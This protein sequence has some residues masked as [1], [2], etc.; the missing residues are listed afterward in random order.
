MI[1]VNRRHELPWH[2]GITVREVLQAMKYTY[3]DIVVR[4]D[5]RVVPDED[6]DTAAIPD[7]ADVRVIHL[8]AGG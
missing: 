6:Y 8:I 2:P 4:V 1:T 5:G 7:G 3:N